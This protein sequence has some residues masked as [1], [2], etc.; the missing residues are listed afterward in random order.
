MR[1]HC[2][3]MQLPLSYE[4][5][6]RT[7]R[8]SSVWVM[9]HLRHALCVLM[10]AASL[11]TVAQDTLPLQET[12]PPDLAD[13]GAP[14][15]QP[16]FYAT[17][18]KELPLVLRELSFLLNTPIQ[19]INLPEILV[20]GEYGAANTT[21]FLDVFTSEF[22]LDWMLLRNEILISATSDR[23]SKTYEFDTELDA[24]GFGHELN[25]KIVSHSFFPQKLTPQRGKFVM[26]V[27]APTVYQEQVVELAK[28]WAEGL[29]A[30]DVLEASVTHA[31]FPDVSP[32]TTER[33]VIL[34]V[35][36][37]QLQNAW[38]TDQ[39]L[40]SASAEGEPVTVPG[41][42][43]VFTEMVKGS[44]SS[45]ATP[46][47][48]L[49]SIPASALL[50]VAGSSGIA[51]PAK[52]A[53]TT[54]QAGPGNITDLP[55]IAVDTRSNAILIYDDLAY[56]DFYENLINDLD[57]PLQMIEL[58]AMVI[59]VNKDKI[60]D[61]GITWNL[62]T[63]GNNVGIGVSGGFAIN[64]TA[65]LGDINLVVNSD[66][67][68]ARLRVLHTNGESKLVSQPSVLA[69]DN[70]VANIETMDRFY[71]RVAGTDT[72]A[73]YPVQTGTK[74]NVTP[75]IIDDGKA[76]NR[77]I[78][79]LVSIR[80]GTINSEADALIDGLPRI[81]E[82]NI[83]TQAVVFHGESLLIG[84][85]IHK[86]DSSSFAKIP[87]LSSLPLLGPLFTQK[88]KVS[89]D[90]V[91]MFLLRPNIIEMSYSR[92]VSDK[93]VYD[94]TVPSTQP[95]TPVVSARRI[96]LPDKIAS[97]PSGIPEELAND[98]APV[99]TAQH[100]E[101]PDQLSDL[102]AGD[103]PIALAR[104]RGGILEM[105]ATTEIIPPATQETLR[106]V[107]GNGNAVLGL[108]PPPNT[109][110]VK[111]ASLDETEQAVAEKGVPDTLAGL[112]TLQLRKLELGKMD[113]NQKREQRHYSASPP[114]LPAADKAGYVLQ[115]GAF[116]SSERAHLLVKKTQKLGFATY[117][118]KNPAGI[119]RVRVGEF[120]SVGEVYAAQVTL[121]HNNIKNSY[122]VGRCCV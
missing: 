90:Y 72:A 55:N 89:R 85:H 1:C 12:V 120:T 16:L 105:H 60:S 99:V 80:D 37:F 70:H 81:Q 21:S 34:G 73:L 56:R 27:E 115:I 83:S 24:L 47:S 2:A 106:P 26:T 3:L 118:E 36:R 116:R 5:P 122:L 119:I 75:H 40:N 66:R 35:M 104:H 63:P 97:E 32:F 10:L 68:L 100:I 28:L 62:Q 39:I 29:L 44:K 91:R 17:S 18:P 61:L 25:R 58:Q 108:A 13:E 49:S 67:F 101:L 96:K 15:E 86:T 54:P 8:F 14:T 4:M 112:T 41:I 51:L 117:S 93:L 57:L 110:P 65:R 71:V 20:E 111:I 46:Q 9:R 107:A 23:V 98:G 42:I 84:G 33:K 11:P 92:V 82:R 6:G 69:M 64:S 78:Q 53:A 7:D 79:M 88:A 48:A 103:M 109:T 31:L 102:V 22:E 95:T 121:A 87:V 38:V 30:D 19:G 45:R 114:S 76:K 113:K 74:L 94:E 77:R 59:D 50:P 43:H 52:A